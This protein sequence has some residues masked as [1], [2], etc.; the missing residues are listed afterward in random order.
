MKIL[1][2]GGRDFSD[3]EHLFLTLSTIHKETPITLLIHGNARG[4]DTLAG[5]WAQE[6]NIP[7]H[8]FPAQWHIYGLRAGIMR[9][10]QMLDKGKPDFVLAFPGGFGTAHM[11]SAT[12]ATQVPLRRA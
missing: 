2:C 7:C 6:N 4:A 12:I 8:V 10:K 1:V 3:K 9:N 5:Q 11:M